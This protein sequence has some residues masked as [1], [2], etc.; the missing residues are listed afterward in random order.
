MSA[1]QQ[2]GTLQAKLRILERKS[3]VDTISVDIIRGIRQNVAE[4]SNGLKEELLLSHL[5]HDSYRSHRAAV[6]V[7]ISSNN[8]DEYEQ[9]QKN[10]ND[11]WLDDED[12]LAWL[13]ANY[14]GRD[15]STMISPRPSPL[16]RFK[17]ATDMLQSEI[18]QCRKFGFDASKIDGAGYCRARMST[19]RS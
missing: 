14:G 13:D 18:K 8:S 17:R 19:D 1:L 9:E 4:V 7:A 3:S 12:T 6:C 10:Q 16:E 2:L 5:Y 15:F 11:L